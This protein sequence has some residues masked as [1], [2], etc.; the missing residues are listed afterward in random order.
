MFDSLSGKQRLILGLFL[1]FLVDL[2]WVGSSELTEYIFKTV[3][4]DKPFF[5]TYFKTAMFVVYLSGFLFKLS[6]R[7]RCHW[8]KQTSAP[9]TENSQNL[10]DPVYIGPISSSLTQSLPSTKNVASRKAVRFSDHTEIRVMADTHAEEANLARLSYS[11]F[12]KRQAEEARRNRKFPVPTVCKLA[13]VFCVLWFL[14]IFAYQEA[15]L[16]SEAAI[17][18]ILSSVSALFTLVL[19]AVWPSGP[20]DK[21]TLSKFLAVLLSLGGTVMVCLSDAEL[22]LKFPAGS[23]WA[24]VGAV[25]YALYLVTLKRKVSDDRQL[26][27]PMFFGFVGLFNVVILWPGLLLLHYT[28]LESFQF[29]DSTQWLLMLANGLIG[30]V[31]SELL[32]LW[33]CFLTS[34]LIGTLALSL[35]TPLTMIFDIFIKNITYNWMFYV[36][37]GPVFLSFLLVT[38]LSHYDNWDP[39]LVGLKK[40]TKCITRS[41]QHARLREMDTET[42]QHLISSAKS[43]D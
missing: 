33:G 39:A 37:V 30:T 12:L 28:K 22:E 21:F 34:S 42:R 20:S 43:S 35:T 1:L 4:Y 24:I 18:N 26:D 40:L 7:Q 31:L 2:I 41:L 14:A 17:V 6:W 8:P 23:M 5:T 25:A 29:P 9:D 11:D 19:A 3:N 38:A 10:S 32:W 13:I 27:V 15:L 36:G 16:L